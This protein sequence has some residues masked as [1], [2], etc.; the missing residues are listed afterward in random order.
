L[1]RPGITSLQAVLG[2]LGFDPYR[3]MATEMVG[4]AYGL[5]D[6]WLKTLQA[7]D[8]LTRQT[9][10]R[11]AIEPFRAAV[12]VPSCLFVEELVG[13]Y[14]NA[15]VCEN[16]TQTSHTPLIATLRSYIT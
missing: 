6:L 9:L 3:H 1:L 7:K 14:P 11:R 16:R 15:K 12:D 4:N 8:K 10:L 13:M 2:Q 5:G